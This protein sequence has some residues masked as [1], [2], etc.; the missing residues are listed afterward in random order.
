VKL[1]WIKQGDSQETGPF[2]FP[3]VQG[4]WRAGTVKVTDQIRRDGDI[5]WHYVRELQPHLDRGA[6]QLTVG[7]IVLVI[8]LAFLILGLFWWCSSL[9]H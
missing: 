2:T 7:K 9:P 1:Y 4:M 3:Q 6:G 8:V 5:V